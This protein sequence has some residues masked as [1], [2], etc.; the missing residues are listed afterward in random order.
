MLNPHCLLC[1]VYHN[2]SRS[3]PRRR[4]LIV[5]RTVLIS[6]P[7]D[8][9]S[10]WVFHEYRGAYFPIHPFPSSCKNILNRANVPRF[11][12]QVSQEEFGGMISAAAALPKKFGFDWWQACG[13]LFVLA[14]NLLFFSISNLTGGRHVTFFLSLQ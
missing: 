5:D 11:I 12:H 3:R 1:L 8:M 7:P 14:N 4:T 9:Q 2:L 13:C 6:T 10:L